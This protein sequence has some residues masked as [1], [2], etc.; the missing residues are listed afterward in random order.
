MR[1]F[2]IKDQTIQE[3]YCNNEYEKKHIKFVEEVAK[4]YALKQI[5]SDKENIEATILKDMAINDNFLREIMDV[6]KS[7]DLY[8]TLAKISTQDDDCF[9]C[10]AHSVRSKQIDEVS[11]LPKLVKYNPFEDCVTFIKQLAR[12]IIEKL[13]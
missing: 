10:L 9:V 8:C 6:T 3:A 13:R 5:L 11:K 1:N 2:W 12:S 7:R 4:N